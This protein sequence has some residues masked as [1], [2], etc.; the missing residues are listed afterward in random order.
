MQS[1]RS[2]YSAI[3]LALALVL[4]SVHTLEARAASWEQVQY[5]GGAYI[6]LQSVSKFYDMTMTRNGKSLLM[7][8]E[9]VLIRGE[10]GSRSAYLNNVHFQLAYPIVSHAGKYLISRIDLSKLIDPVL[11]PNFINNAKSFGTVVLDP[12]HG[13]RDR[14]ARGHHGY[15]ADYTLRVARMVRAHLR[16]LG[17]KVEMTRDSDTYVSLERRVQIANQFRDAVCISIHFNSAKNSSATGIE[18]FCVSPPGVTHYGRSLQ[19]RDKKAVPGN[20]VDSASMA[21]ATAVHQRSIRRTGNKEDRGIKH[22]RYNVLSGIR[23]PTVLIEGGF[24]S[25]PGES[26][27]VHT[28]DYQQKLAL[29]IAEAVTIYHEAISPQRRR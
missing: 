6:T 10:V 18:T 28:N 13:G 16:R 25:N 26:R 2:I 7:E 4:G 12:G 21:L 22:A 1:L 29:G 8:N 9:K 19:A 11:R 14:G 20:F 15:E 5:K 24:I 23:I 3:I 27:M 17:Y